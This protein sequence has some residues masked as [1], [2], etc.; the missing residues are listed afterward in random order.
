[1]SQAAYLEVARDSQKDGRAQER[2]AFDHVIKLLT[3]AQKEGIASR[4]CVEAMLATSRLWSVLM[5]DLGHEGNALPKPLR[6]QLISIG[7]WIVRCCEEVRLGERS[8][9]S[10]ILDICVMIRDGLK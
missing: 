4:V 6:A 8:D 10:G 7:I 3:R 1:M 9:L 5:E 2:E